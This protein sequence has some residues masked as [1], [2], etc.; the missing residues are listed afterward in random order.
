MILLYIKFAVDYGLST[1]HLKKKKKSK[2][3][4]YRETSTINH[5]NRFES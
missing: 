5:R 4:P 1:V 3:C 2:P